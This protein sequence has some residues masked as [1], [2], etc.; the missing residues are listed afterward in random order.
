M[1]ISRAFTLIE[2]IFVIVLIGILSVVAIPKF[3]NLTSHA[4]EANV[5]GTV[6]S[7]SLAIANIHSKWVVNDEFIW[8]PDGDGKSNLNSNGYPT[9]LDANDGKIFSYL[10]QNPIPACSD[11]L[12]GCWKEVDTNIYKYYFLPDKALKII[13]IPDSGK[14]E[15]DDGDNIDKAKCEEILFK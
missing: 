7:L 5:K 9:T 13:Y 4:K 14:I 10:L 2:L 6:S 15:C 11:K 12:V 1:L 3:T 8:D